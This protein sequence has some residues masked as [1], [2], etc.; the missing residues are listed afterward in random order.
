M[1]VMDASAVLAWLFR[2]PGHETVGEFIH[3]AL[4]SSVNFAEVLG[5]F[6]RD[7]VDAVAV[8]ERLASVGQIIPFSQ[9]HS[10]L[11]AALVQQGQ[12]LGLSLGDRA[13]LA[14]AVEQNLPVL[15]ADR[16]WAELELDVEIRIIR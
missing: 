12:R 8:A 15:T 11:A 6:A 7:G 16:V 1:I 14:T 9:T 13:C 10:I 5:R 3:Q 4:I 2:E